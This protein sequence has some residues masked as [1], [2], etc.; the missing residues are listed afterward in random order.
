M[1]TP[2]IE[3]LV[4]AALQADAEDAMNRTNTAEQLQALNDASVRDHRKRRGLQAVGA[5]AAAAAAAVAVAVS[6]H[7]GDSYTAPPAGPPPNPQQVSEAERVA[8]GFFD[9]LVF[10][11]RETAAT[12]VAAGARLTMGNVMG[13]D[14]VDDEWTLRNRWDEATGWQVGTPGCHGAA[15]RPPDIDV[16][17]VVTAHQLGSD[18]LGRGPF[19]GNVYVIT[20]REG[21]IVHLTLT[22]AHETNGFADTM[23]DPFWAWMDEAHPADERLMAAMEDPGASPARVDRSLRLWQRRTQQYVDAVQAGKTQ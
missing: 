1:N 8:R 23:W 20:V 2:E 4:T 3:R 14:A 9:A 11:D 17:C 22:T 15:F 18:Q 13:N 7:G 12:Y 21:A 6:W 5:L 10:F 19:G 16:R